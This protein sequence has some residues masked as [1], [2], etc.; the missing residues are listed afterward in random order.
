MSIP[1][2]FFIDDKL[3]GV[4]SLNLNLIEHAP[5]GF[6]QTVIHLEDRSLKLSKSGIKYPVDNQIQFVFDKKSNVYCVL[7]KMRKLVDNKP[8][9]MVLNYGSEM[10][11][12][13]HHQVSQT[14]YQLV[15]DAYNLD[16][17]KIYGH[18]VD[19]F[20]CHNSFIESEL[21]KLFPSRLNDIFFLSHGVTIPDQFRK[22]KKAD[23]PLRLLFLGRL[24]KSKGIFDLPQIAAL[25]RKKNIKVKWTCI[26][27]GPEESDF[28]KSWSPD[29]EVSFLSPATNKE[30][31]EICQQHDLFVLPTKFEGT[32]VSLLETMSVGLVP[33]ITSL[34]GGIEEIVKTDI[35]YAIKINDNNAFADA[36]A[37]LHNNR[38]KLEQLSI[39]CRNK[40]IEDFNITNT[41]KKYYE[42][43]SQY[44]H[45]KKEKKLKKIRVGSRLDHPMIPE[46]VVRIIR[47]VVN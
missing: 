24:A 20:I 46:M 18:L 4:S 27:S 8:G 32:P 36:I 30:V 26:G 3:G 16:L 28:K 45:Y 2:T 22:E 19:V 37:E 5:E 15:H 34:P 33:V 17:A 41:S 1:I 10:A 44:K 13:D 43:F 12:L 47:N 7:E 40:I 11:M 6:S 25:L 9:V 14:T 42:L 35:G 31:L 29:D 39:N 38:L 23:E 21:K